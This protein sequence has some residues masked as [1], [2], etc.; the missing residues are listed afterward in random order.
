MKTIYHL[1]YLDK[2]SKPFYQ[3]VKDNFESNKH[4]FTTYGEVNSQYVSDFSENHLTNRV[5]QF[6]KTIPNLT[7]SDKVILHGAF[8]TK[9]IFFLML[10]PWLW[11]K[12]YWVIWG[13]DLEFFVNNSNSLSY[14]T[15]KFVL[16]RIN[17][18]VTYLPED[19]EKAKFLLSSK[20]SFKEC[21]AYPSN[22]V[23]EPESIEH[24]EK[25]DYKVVLVGNSADPSNCHY[26]I[27]DKLQKE[28]NKLSKVIVPLSYGDGVYATNVIKQG[29][30]LFGDKFQPLTKMLPIETYRDILKEVDFAFFNHNRQQAMGNIIYL[31]SIGKTV[32]M[33]E[34]TPSWFFFKSK[35]IILKSVDDD[36]A[37]ISHLDVINNKSSVVNYFN[38]ENLVKQWAAIFNE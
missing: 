34:N 20:S 6:I 21:I 33:R 11:K 30:A 26:E 3:L 5:F 4:I 25:D 36:F 18:Y 37:Y 9:V 24:I 7:R 10:Q 19:Y 13:K 22:I 14:F 31:L 28:I 23:S 17:S 2:F 16:S 27:F 29:A 35:G 8:S 38:K 15:R 1:L 32:F 12:T